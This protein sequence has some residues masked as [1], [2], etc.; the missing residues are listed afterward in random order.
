VK[1]FLL[2]K[3]TMIK[4][5]YNLNFKFP[6]LKDGFKFPMDNRYHYAWEPEKF[7]S[8]E[9]INF[10]EN[11]N[12]MLIT[13]RVFKI[14][15]GG[16]S[17]IH[18]DGV[19]SRKHNSAINWIFGSTSSAMHWYATTNTGHMSINTEG[20][21]IEK[22]QKWDLT[23]VEEIEKASFLGPTLVRTDVPHDVTNFDTKNVRWCV[24]I[25]TQKSLLTW[26]ESVEFFKPYMI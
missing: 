25:R 23:Q 8:Q 26:E 21:T 4:N 18:I 14:L 7:I 12:V 19:N 1:N 24:S 10:F 9:A 6:I 22:L 11:I 5:H 20:N 17:R 15:P 3:T 16:R 13:C 2:N